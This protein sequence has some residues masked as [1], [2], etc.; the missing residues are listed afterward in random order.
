MELG[1]NGS[2]DRSRPYG[3]RIETLARVLLKRYG[4]GFRSL[5]ARESRLP[6][7]RELAMAYRRLERAA[8]S[9]AGAS[10]PDSAAS[11]SRCPTRSGGYARCES[12]KRKAN[13]VR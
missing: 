8:R 4:V 10:Y 12:W 2:C 3:E 6:P 5:L 7:W 9:A 11:S 13:W 1:E